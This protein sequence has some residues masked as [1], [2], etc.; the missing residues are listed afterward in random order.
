MRDVYYVYDY[1]S[2]FLLGHSHNPQFRHIVF[3]R[4]GYHNLGHVEY[5]LE[6]VSY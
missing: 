1:D 5:N 3:L 6:I 2:E 4:C